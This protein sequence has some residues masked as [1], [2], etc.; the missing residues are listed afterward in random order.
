LVRAEA[1]VFGTRGTIA[2]VL[3]GTVDSG[4]QLTRGRLLPFDSAP[5]F[6]YGSELSSHFLVKVSGVDIQLLIC[7]T[8]LYFSRSLLLPH[9]SRERDILLSIAKAQLVVCL[10]AVR[11]PGLSSQLRS[12]TTMFIMSCCLIIS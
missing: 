3:L 5:V 1:I 2:D 4:E 9:K 7:N 10:S 6:Q 12:L 8:P 11:G